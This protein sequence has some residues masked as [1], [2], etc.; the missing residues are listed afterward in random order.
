MLVVDCAY[1]HLRM[2]LEMKR[3]SGILAPICFTAFVI[4]GTLDAQN[5][6]FPCTASCSFQYVAANDPSNGNVW[7]GLA[8]SFTAP[9]DPS[10]LFG[11]YVGNFSGAPINDTV[12]YSLYARG[13][14]FSNPLGQVSATATLASGAVELPQVSFSSIPL[15]PGTEYTVVVSLPN[16]GLPTTG[17]PG[18]FNPLGP[19]TYSTLGVLI[20]STSNAY[21]GG[22]F[23]YV[24][25]SYDESTFANWDLAFN[26]SPG[27]GGNCPAG[28]NGPGGFYGPTQACV[29]GAI[30]PLG[31]S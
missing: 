11:F 28:V 8:Q 17:A 22:R 5:I 24:G 31:D 6:N 19:G 30:V 4:S 2:L 1:L 7:T 3:I 14:Q 25:S 18:V 15:R 12:L 26:V 9:D 23:Y 13:G 20:Y 21:A 29:A 27:A 16:R 10:V